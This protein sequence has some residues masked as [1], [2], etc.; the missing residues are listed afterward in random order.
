M[1]KYVVSSTGVVTSTDASIVD[2]LNP[3]VPL[4]ESSSNVMRVATYVALAFLVAR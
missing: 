2:V 1:K 4:V 3:A